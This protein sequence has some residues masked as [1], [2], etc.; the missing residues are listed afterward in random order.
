MGKKLSRQ[1]K[2]LLEAPKSHMPAT[3]KESALLH[4]VLQSFPSV[5]NRAGTGIQEQ[6][7]CNKGSAFQQ[8]LFKDLVKESVMK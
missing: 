2:P 4:A 5:R 8:L 1:E 3:L 6:K 7:F